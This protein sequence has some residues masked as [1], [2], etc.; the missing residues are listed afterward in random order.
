[1]LLD[2]IL[3]QKKGTVRC[4][5]EAKREGEVIAGSLVSRQGRRVRHREHGRGNARV[6]ICGRLIIYEN[7]RYS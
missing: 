1:M 2:G 3:R 5:G 7:N 4:Q 6:G